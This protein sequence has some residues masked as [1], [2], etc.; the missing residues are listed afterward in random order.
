MSVPFLNYALVELDNLG[1][2]LRAD[3]VPTVGWYRC[4]GHSLVVSER[5]GWT[6]DAV[7]AKLK[8]GVWT[9]RAVW[10]RA[11]DGSVIISLAGYLSWVMGQECASSATAL[12][13]SLSNTVAP[14]GANESMS[15]VPKRK[16]A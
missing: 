1:L 14:A 3:A 16:P 15:R 9:E 6:E 8:K 12:L 5:S 13:K 11:P 2:G 7:R 10:R 4:R